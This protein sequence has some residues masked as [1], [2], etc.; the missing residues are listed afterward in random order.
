MTGD[1]QSWIDRAMNNLKYG[2]VIIIIHNGEVVRIDRK[3]RK[4][5][6]K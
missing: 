3:E 1:L 6:D 4:Q 5:I 2:E